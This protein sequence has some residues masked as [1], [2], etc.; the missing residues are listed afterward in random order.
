LKRRLDLVVWDLETGGLD[1]E[2]HEILTV[3][4]KAYSGDDWEPYPADEGEFA[5]PVMKVE[6]P[7]NLDE[8]ALAVNGITR[9]Q[10][11]N[12]AEPRVVWESFFEWV[13]RF[14]R[15]KTRGPTTAPLS[16]GKNII[17]FDYKFLRKAMAKHHPKGETGLV[18]NRRPILDLEVLTYLWFEDD[19][20]WP[21]Y[22]MD[23][24]RPYFGLS[25]EGA[26]TA[27]VDVRQTGLILTR[28]LKLHRRL[29]RQKSGGEA[30]IKFRGSL[31]GA[32]V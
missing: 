29:R 24:M 27:I 13:K 28:M 20:D 8:R 10:V 25:S 22:S 16:G 31:A 23:A 18:F 17:D 30:T 26:H 3:A 12:G 7:D 32:T 19:A 6:D 21:G 15:G 14:N 5:S 4:A 9:D 1:H 11:E 2:K